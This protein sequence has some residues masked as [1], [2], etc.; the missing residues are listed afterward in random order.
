MLTVNYSITKEDY[1]HYYTFVVWEAPQNRKKRTQYYLKQLIP[2][3]FFALAFYYTG[4]F[5]RDSLFILVIAGFMLLI[6]ALSLF[7]VKSNI[8]RQADKIVSNPDN[9][10][11]FLPGTL[12]ASDTGLTIR[13]EI[14]ESKYQWKGFIR[15]QESAQYYF[16]FL[17]AIQGVIIPKRIF[18]TADEK[19]QFEKLL[20]QHLSFEAELG[21]MIRS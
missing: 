14:A 17:S 2:L 15:K 6:S 8:T 20:Q 19:S 3:V 10:S 1:C 16:L 18:N 4:L 13:N 5:R 11:I 21:H 7:G 9:Q 12:T